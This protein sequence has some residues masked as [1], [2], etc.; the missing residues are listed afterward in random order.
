MQDFLDMKD[1]ATIISRGI[2]ELT[3]CGHGNKLFSLHGLRLED[4]CSLGRADQGGMIEII[5]LVML[6]KEDT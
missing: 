5:G 3:S 4:R 2:A 1:A 6:C